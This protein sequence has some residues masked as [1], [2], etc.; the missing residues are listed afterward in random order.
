VVLL[1]IL[2]A[3]CSRDAKASSTVK[4]A[5]ELEQTA[6]H[7]V[8]GRRDDGR[9]E[10]ID[11]TSGGARTTVSFS[12]RQEIPIVGIDLRK[13][14]GINSSDKKWVGRCNKKAKC[15]ITKVGDA[16]KTFL[17]SRKDILTP[18]YWSPDGRFVFF[19]RQA[20]R[21]RFPLRCSLEDLTQGGEDI[22]STV[23][24]GYPYG[25]LSWYKLTEE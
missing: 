21:W 20:P 3:G 15:Q 6:N 17:V 8:I 12:N 5:V 11:M 24:R 2:V 18:L 23:C 22:V 7:I 1:C 9:L 4:E 19:V 14:K 10:Y 16:N 25:S 13:S